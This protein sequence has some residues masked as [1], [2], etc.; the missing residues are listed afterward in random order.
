MRTRPAEAGRPRIHRGRLAASLLCI[1]WSGLVWPALAAAT[2]YVP[3]SDSQVLAELPAG[4]SFSGS[5]IRQQAAAR[6]DVAVPL[7]QFYISQSRATGDLR[8]LGYADAA[9][10]HWQHHTP[11]LPAVLVLEATILQSRHSFDAALAKLDQALA[12]RPEDAQAWLTRATVLRVLGRYD[13]A[14]ASCAHLRATADPALAQLC[15]ASLLGVSGH[16]RAAY[17][18]L[19]GLPEAPLAV[20]ARAWRFSELGELAASLGDTAAAA[21]WF[22]AALRLVPADLYTRAAY[23]D[24]LLSEGRPRDTLELLKGYD[25]MEPMLLRIAIAQRSLK[26]P[27]F[28][29]TRELLA[30]AFSVEEQRGEAVHRRE[31]ARFLLDVE[32]DSAAALRAAQENWRVQREPADILILLRAAQASRQPRAAMPAMQFIQEHRTEDVRFDPYLGRAR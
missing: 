4:T 2:P 3:A 9:L 13:E 23:A 15:A 5:A 24:L 10:A 21:N 18:Q 25:S 30:S 28:D 6:L 29:A 20:E 16:L 7:A 11:P 8:F 32:A 22:T 1:V 26:D 12:L 14:S 17:T 19:T 27:Q 31:Q